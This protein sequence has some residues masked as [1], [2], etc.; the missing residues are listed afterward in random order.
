MR[1]GIT[2]LILL[3]TTGALATAGY[4]YTTRVLLEGEAH[5]HRWRVRRDALPLGDGSMLIQ[6]SEPGLEGQYSRFETVVTMPSTTTPEQAAERAIEF[7]RDELGIL[8]P[9]RDQND[10]DAGDAGLRLPAARTEPLRLGAQTLPP[11]VSPGFANMTLDLDA[12]EG[13]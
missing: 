11:G 8:P 12:L 7:I 9:P 13:G 10:L 6:V 5:G 1:V 3:A 2:L 4:L